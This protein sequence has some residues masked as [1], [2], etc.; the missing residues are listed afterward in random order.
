[1]QAKKVVPMHYATFPP[2]IGT[3]EQLR[4]LIKDLGTE[5]IVLKPGETG[6]Q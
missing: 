6:N 4:E 1:M 2:L 3:P 5:V